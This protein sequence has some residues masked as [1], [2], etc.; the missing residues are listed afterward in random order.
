MTKQ[1]ETKETLIRAPNE[2]VLFPIGKEHKYN[3]KDHK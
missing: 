2:W 3:F 1:L